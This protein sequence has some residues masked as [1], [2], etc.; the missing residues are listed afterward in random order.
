M[1][2]IM[3][4]IMLVIMCMISCSAEE[5]YDRMI[6][7]ETSDGL[8]IKADVYDTS[9]PGAPVILLFHQARFSRGEY[10]SIAPRLNDLGYNCIAIDQ[11]S[12]D[13]IKGV[14]NETYILAEKLGLGTEYIDA[15][16]DLELLL[17]HVKKTYPNQK[18]ILWGSSYS[19]SLSM[20]LATQY[21][22]DIAAVLTFS[23]GSYFTIKGKSIGEYAALLT[24]PVFMTCARDEVPS[25]REIFDKIQGAGKVFFA[26]EAEGFHGSKALW[27]EHDGNEFYWEAVASFL[28]TL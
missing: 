3:L 16:P 5:T 14:K 19:A 21:P 20:V 2:A 7:L 10:R 17:S 28:G 6:L 25:R 8:A 18:I 15:Y 22:E 4:V 27:P 24:C 12:G 13:K 26:P 9:Q 11:R 1:L 23:P